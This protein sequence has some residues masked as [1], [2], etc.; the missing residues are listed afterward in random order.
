LQW[1][2]ESYLTLNDESRTRVDE[3]LTGTGCEQLM[4]A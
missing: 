4:I 3:I 1:I 2:N